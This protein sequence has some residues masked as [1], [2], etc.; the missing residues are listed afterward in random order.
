MRTLSLALFLISTLAMLATEAAPSPPPTAPHPQTFD[1]EWAGQKMTMQKYFIV[2]LKSGPNRNQSQ[3][4][5]AELQQ[6]HLAYLGGLY[7]KGIIQL[8]GPTDGEDEIRGFSV[9][10]VATKAEAL[11]LAGEDPMVKNGRLSVEV[12]P[13]WL[14]K[15]SGVK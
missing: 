5:A 6:Q 12:R 3:E 1:Y 9:Y 15:G 10:A 14:V 2:F 11:H 7:E 4:E 13:W 8:N